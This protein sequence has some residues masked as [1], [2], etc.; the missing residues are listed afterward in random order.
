M[1]GQL[2]SPYGVLVVK[3]A[4]AHPSLVPGAQLYLFEGRGHLPIFTATGEFCE[5]LR[6]FVL[7]GTVPKTTR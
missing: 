6:S 5:V 1:P 7:T 4:A 2:T 3:V